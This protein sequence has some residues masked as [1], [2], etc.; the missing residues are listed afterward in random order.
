MV[1][2]F[3]RNIKTHIGIDNMKYMDQW[4]LKGL[5]GINVCMGGDMLNVEMYLYDNILM[6]PITKNKLYL[7]N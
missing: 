6:L 1:P 2:R 3:C 5:T 4:I 7:H